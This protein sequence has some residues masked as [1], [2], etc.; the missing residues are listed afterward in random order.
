MPLKQSYRLYR[1][2]IL[3]EPGQPVWSAVGKISEGRFLLLGQIET[4][5]KSEG[6]LW[7]EISQIGA[8]IGKSNRGKLDVLRHRRKDTDPHLFGYLKVLEEMYAAAAWMCR[9]DENAKYLHL[10]LL[11]TKKPPILKAALSRAAM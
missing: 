5:S 3:S 10:T 4:Y 7:L 6:A 1:D 8:E 9:D 11:K 2:I